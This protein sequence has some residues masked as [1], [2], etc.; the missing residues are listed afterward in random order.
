MT[1]WNERAPAKENLRMF[2]APGVWRRYA[3]QIDDK[4]K[5]VTEP[6]CAQK[7]ESILIN[8]LNA[9]NIL[10]LTGAGSSFSAGN[11]KTSALKDR[12]A[13]RL[14]DLWNAVKA[15]VG[16][17]V[18]EDVI[19]K[20]PHGAAI[21]DIEKLLTQC[22]LFVAL[23]GGADGDGKVISEFIADAET[24]ILERVD[25][26]DA[27]TNLPA[28]ESILRKL[29]RRGSRKPRAKVFTTNYDLCYEYAARRQRFVIVDGF[30][31]AAPPVYDRSHFSLDIVRRDSSS[32]APTYF[33][34][35][36]QLYKLHG[37]IDW[38]RTAGDIVRSRAAEG[39]PVLIY[40]RDSK[41]QEA[42]E[43]PFLDMMGAFQTALREPDTTLFIAGF[44][45]SDSHIAQPLLAALE[46]NMNFRLVICDPGFL[47]D[48]KVKDD[49]VT[50]S[51]A[52]SPENPFHQKLERLAKAGDHRLVMLHGRFEDFAIALPDLVAETERESHAV[53]V[54]VL[55]ETGSQEGK[56]GA[57]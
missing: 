51:D 50:L 1:Y 14:I 42:F 12:T 48:E 57:A 34:N 52:G 40:P 53:R 19:K 21:K 28:H 55:R 47:G 2:E 33:E 23:Y 25:F 46:S 31:H 54:R 16:A 17:A 56:G 4:D 8:S 36:F 18:F 7:L 32:E 29:A 44:S 24:A 41:Y 3:D 22:K 9:T 26:V 11:D 37:S 13:P 27:A 10:L 35:V 45:F 49:P 43:P 20:I 6:G 15:K 39:A 30:S 5:T 38:R